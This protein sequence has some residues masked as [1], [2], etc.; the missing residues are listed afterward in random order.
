MKRI[1]TWLAPVMT[2]VLF[3]T[4]VIAPSAVAKC[5]HPCGAS[6]LH[7]MGDS[8]DQ[9]VADSCTAGQE[10]CEKTPEGKKAGVCKSFESEDAAIGEK[11]PLKNLTPEPCVAFYA[12]L[13]QLFIEWE[14]IG[15]EANRPQAPPSQ[16][17]R[18]THGRGAL[19]LLI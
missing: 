6:H 3:W 19:P 4:M 7:A 11:A 2:L 5:E 16:P 1:H 12:P 14:L 15:L 8:C 17:P 10:P 13:N 18:E 9:G